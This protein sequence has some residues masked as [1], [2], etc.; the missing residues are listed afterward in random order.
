MKTDQKNTAADFD[1]E[2]CMYFDYSDDEDSGKE[3]QVNMDEDEMCRLLSFG[4]KRCPYFRFWDEYKFV[5]KQN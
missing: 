1:C 2:N 4:Q 5:R 3:C